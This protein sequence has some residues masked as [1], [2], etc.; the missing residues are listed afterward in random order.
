MRVVESLKTLDVLAPYDGKTLGK[1]PLFNAEAI[2]RA[3][4]LASDTF[5]QRENWLSVPK[6]LEI[7]TNFASLIAEHAEELTLTAAQEGGKPLMD[8]QVEL[9]RCV[10]SIRVCAD[11]LRNQTAEPVPMGSNPASEHRVTIQKLEPIGV[12]VAVSAFN[13]PLNLIA[14]QVGPAVAA[15]CPVIIKPAGDTPLSCLALVKLLYQAGLPKQWC[16]FV[17]PESTALAEAL[18]TDSRVSFFSFIG[19]AKVGWYLRSKLAAGTRC[20]LEHGGVAPVIIDETVD[21]PTVL[22][23]LMKG[24]FY[25]AGQVCVSVQRIFVH[26]SLAKS[27]ADAMAKQAQTLVVGDPTDADTEVGPL[28]RQ[29]EVSRVHEWVQEAVEDGAELLCGGEV[30]ANQCYAPTVLYNPSAEAKVSVSEIFGPVVCIYPYEAVDDAIQ[31]AN[32]LDVAFQAAVYSQNIN[33]ALDVADRLDASAVMVNDHTA[34][35]V[36]WMPFAGL[37]YSGLGVGGI[38]HTI[39][40]MQI[41]KMTVLK[42]GS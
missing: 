7:L 13:H 18:V 26:E 27:L 16:Q 2:E 39:K 11:T 36:D 32:G 6:R 17:L 9:V 14:H 12:V 24:G 42:I 19:S 37:R 33:Q 15:G 8:S 20:A 1:V 28:I 35:R 41:S 25:H 29:G 22:P 21:I 31:R 4:V 10:D 23:S 38:P 30:L 34:F 5:K 40:D 3:L